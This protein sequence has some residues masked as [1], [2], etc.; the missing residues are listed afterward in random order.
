MEIVYR[1]ELR[2]P[3]VGFEAFVEETLGDP[4]GWERAGFR[5][6]R[7]DDATAPFRIVL[8]E[9]DEVHELCK[10]YDVY[11]KYSCQNGPVV[12]LNAERWRHATPEWTGDLEGYRRMLVNHEVGHLLGMRHPGVQCPGAGPS[13]ADH[14]PAVHR[15]ERLPAQPVAA[16]A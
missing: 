7:R 3:D 15:A 11:R 8:G 1:L 2:T 6:V 13:G 12:A 4:R 16:A 9:A 5:F 10:P 14:G